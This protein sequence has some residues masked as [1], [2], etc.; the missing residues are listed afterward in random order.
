MLDC[1]L[2]MWPFSIKLTSTFQQKPR[3]QGNPL[4]RVTLSNQMHPEGKITPWVATKFAYRTQ[5]LPQKMLIRREIIYSTEKIGTFTMCVF[6]NCL[7]FFL[8]GGAYFLT[9]DW[10]WTTPQPIENHSTNLFLKGPAQDWK[11]LRTNNSELNKKDFF[12]KT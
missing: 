2:G 8:L 7:L 10:R 1:W 6:L 12:G 3:M 5:P 4:W 9:R 11:L